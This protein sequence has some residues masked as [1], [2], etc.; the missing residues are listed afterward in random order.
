M[1]I[2]YADRYR[3]LWWSTEILGL[4]EALFEKPRPLKYLL[5]DQFRSN[6]RKGV[7]KLLIGCETMNHFVIFSTLDID[8]DDVGM[9]YIKGPIE[10][11]NKDASI[12]AF[13]MLVGSL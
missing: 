12:I 6:I 11:T 8:L 4:N 9:F 1:T 2:R 5:A 10:L 3:V 13:K 7:S